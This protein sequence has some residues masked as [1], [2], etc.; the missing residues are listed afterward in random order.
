MFLMISVR[1]TW[2][3]IS[4]LVSREAWQGGLAAELG[5]TGG[6]LGTILLVQPWISSGK[7]VF[8]VRPAM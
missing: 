4:L 6:Q 5:G 1:M 7:V 3:T 2:S 8:K